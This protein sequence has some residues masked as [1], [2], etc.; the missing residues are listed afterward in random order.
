MP[1]V[2]KPIEPKAFKVKPFTDELKD[3]LK[4][5][6]NG[7][8][9][10][11]QAGVK[12]WSHKPKFDV[13][14]KINPNGGASIAVDTDDRIYTYV[15]EG[16]RPHI[17]KPRKAKALRFQNTYTAKT[18]PGVIQSRAGGKSGSVV[19]RQIVKHPGFKG[20]FFSKPIKKKWGPLFSRQI[21]RSYNRAVQLS[22]HSI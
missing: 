12:T 13:E 5:V 22:G 11:Y 6:E 9:K 17:I 21:T 19:Y 8:L 3:A 2:F 14:T 20:R 4:I 18:I 15:H 7:M 10:D 16:T 1:I